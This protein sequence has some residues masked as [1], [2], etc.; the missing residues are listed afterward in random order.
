[1]RESARP[2]THRNPHHDTGREASQ[3]YATEQEDYAQGPARPPQDR[4]GQPTR[5]ETGRPEKRPR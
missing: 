5:P 2:D 1:M 3:P 4:P